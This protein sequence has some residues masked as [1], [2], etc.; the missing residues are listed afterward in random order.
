MK[1]EPL[2]TDDYFKTSITY[3]EDKVQQKKTL[4]ENGAE[5]VK[6]WDLVYAF[7]FD[8]QLHNA[9][10]K[11]SAGVPVSE[12]EPLIKDLAKNFI[13]SIKHPT[14]KNSIMKDSFFVYWEC[15]SILSLS[16]IIK[17]PRDII[18][19]L[20]SAIDLLGKDMLIDKILSYILPERKIHNKLVWPKE[21]EKLNS[22]FDTGSE[23]RSEIMKEYLKGW[24]KSM[25]KCSWYGSH[26]DPDTLAFFGYWSLETAAIT[27]LLK[28]DDS[29]FRDMLYYPK[30]FV[31]FARQK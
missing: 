30:D 22:V 26:K 29:L 25:R 6:R 23:T 3:Y 10:N 16:I 24:Y 13:T 20:A 9:F 18:Q 15:L 27:F 11:Y 31:E 1:R 14:A 21:Y 12:I 2:L 28:I 8:A 7:L 5:E 19:E 4:I 17:S